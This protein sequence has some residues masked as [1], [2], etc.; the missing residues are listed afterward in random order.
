M[1][2]LDARARCGDGAAAYYNLVLSRVFEFILIKRGARVYHENVYRKKKIF[3]RGEEAK[4]KKNVWKSLPI[5][6][7]LYTSCNSYI[8]IL[9]R[10]SFK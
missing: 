7:Y 3:K 5:L 9:N 6:C 1:A 2:K 8:E 4:V 10:Y